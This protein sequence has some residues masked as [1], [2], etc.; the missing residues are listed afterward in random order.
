[1]ASER[2]LDALL[3]KLADRMQA[4]PLKE[5]HGMREPKALRPSQP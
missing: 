5:N 4:Q 2:L 3:W 1:M